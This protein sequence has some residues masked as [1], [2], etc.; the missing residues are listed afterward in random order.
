[1][2]SPKSLQS[3][4]PRY[5]AV[6]ERI[7][8]DIDDGTLT[9]GMQ[10]PTQRELAARLGVD[11]TT[12]SRAYS[13]AT[14]R[15]L[16]AG[17]VGRGTFVRANAAAF[18]LTA[19]RGGEEAPVD[20][21]LNLPPAPVLEQAELALADTLRALPGS[22]AFRGLLE[23]Q[24]NAGRPDHREAG[25]S[26]IRLR[27]VERPA[28]QVIVAAGA[29]HALT[30]LL[31]TYVPAGATVMAE[32]ST[33]PV[34]KVLAEQLRLNLVGVAMDDEGL[35]PDAFR[36]ACARGA[37]VL[38]CIPTL[39]NPTST[40][41]SAGR[42]RA[43][44]EVARE[45]GVVI[46]EDDT[47]GMLPRQ[48]PPALSAFE[49]ERSFLIS[50]LS[51]TVAPGLRVAYIAAPTERAAVQVAA[52]VRA[53]SWMSTP[54]TAEIATRW[55]RDGVAARLLAGYQTEANIRQRVAAA[56]L[57]NCEW[58]S[59]PE[60]YHGWL[61]LS[62]GWSTAE[63]VMQARRLGIIVTPGDAFSI[64][65]DAGPA[66][67]RLSLSAARSV[68]QLEVALERVS[69]LLETGPDMASSLI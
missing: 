30:V 55:I 3:H 54:L 41:M 62:A 10:L 51:K 24:P 65:R 17:Q 21:S 45:F 25:A 53:T 66:A 64:D 33:Y 57:A 68:A 8:R 15:G 12:V 26:W 67:V 50:S 40:L 16:I 28:S 37:R 44:A 58:H 38:Y 18:A 31:T 61:G 13:E 36:E 42:R 1:M 9:A 56:A 11:L 43:I 27:G 49:P 46:I 34:F 32:A 39:Q 19:P 59:H 48:S 47:Y 60:S 23:Y 20:L 5:L 35:L 4:G 6:V 29:Q 2:W 63:F 14:R 7:Q 52:G 22:P 69:R